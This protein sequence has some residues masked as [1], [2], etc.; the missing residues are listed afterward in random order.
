MSSFKWLF[1]CLGLEVC[2]CGQPSLILQCFQ[3]LGLHFSLQVTWNPWG[4]G[5]SFLQSKPTQRSKFLMDTFSKQC[6]ASLMNKSGT[7]SLKTPPTSKQVHFTY[8]KTKRWSSWCRCLNE[9]TVLFFSQ[10]KQLSSK[11]QP[12]VTQ[13]RTRTSMKWWKRSLSKMELTH[14]SF[15]L[16]PPFARFNLLYIRIWS[17]R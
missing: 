17:T 2:F 13:K 11:R 6:K 16:C 4:A 12:S 5:Q 15:S 1:S 3:L 10:A 8:S 9:R 7:C 14:S